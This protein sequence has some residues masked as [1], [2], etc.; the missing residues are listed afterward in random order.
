MNKKNCVSNP[1]HLSCQIIPSGTGYHLTPPAN[2][3]PDILL[4]LPGRPGTGGCSVWEHWGTCKAPQEPTKSSAAIQEM[5]WDLSHVLCPVSRHRLRLFA[6]VFWKKKHLAARWAVLAVCQLPPKG[7]SSCSS[8]EPGMPYGEPVWQDTLWTQGQYRDQSFADLSAVSITPAMGT[9]PRLVH[10]G[11]D[12]ASH[13]NPRPPHKTTLC[14]S[15]AL[16]SPKG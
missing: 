12:P 2:K 6:E 3:Q 15:A 7:A 14:L 11:S 10:Y 9:Q 13:L 1:V 8:H 4:L 5:P 16:L